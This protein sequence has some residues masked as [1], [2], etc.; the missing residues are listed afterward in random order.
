MPGKSRS[1]ENLRKRAKIVRPSRSHETLSRTYESPAPSF[2]LTVP[3]KKTK[4]KCY[5]INSVGLKFFEE[6]V[7]HH[8]ENNWIGGEKD[9]LHEHFRNHRITREDY[10]S[11]VWMLDNYQKN[12]DIFIERVRNEGTF[13]EKSGSGG[14]PIVIKTPGHWME[15]I[16]Q[17]Q[18]TLNQVMAVYKPALNLAMTIDGKTKSCRR[19]TNVANCTTPCSVKKGKCTYKPKK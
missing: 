6:F 12:Y 3:K 9:H 13:I 5:T 11:L 16:M 15:A 7:K 17:L 18:N 10:D 8:R 4:K 2:T 19:I 14:K 1:Q